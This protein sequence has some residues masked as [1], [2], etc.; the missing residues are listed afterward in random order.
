[1]IT[2][3]EIKN[4]TVWRAAEP[5]C[6]TVVVQWVDRNG[7]LVLGEPDQSAH[8]GTCMMPHV[9][10]GLVLRTQQQVADLLNRWQATRLPCMMVIIPIPKI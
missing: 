5:M 1:M 2:A 4:G 6:W 3:D 10:D 8:G 9:R 7:W